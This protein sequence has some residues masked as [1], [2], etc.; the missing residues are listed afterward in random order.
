[1][2][3][4]PSIALKFAFSAPAHS[5]TITLVWLA[6]SRHPG[7]MLGIAGTSGP[8]AAPVAQPAD[9]TAAANAKWRIPMT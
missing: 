5:V 9:A 3:P 7:A 4:L 2:A 1:M 6:P 8:E